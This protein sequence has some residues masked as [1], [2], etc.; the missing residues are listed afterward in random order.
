MRYTVAAQSS[1]KVRSSL[2]RRPSG[3]NAPL[4]TVRDLAVT[5]G[6]ICYPTTQTLNAVCVCCL[7]TRSGHLRNACCVA[8]SLR[9]QTCKSEGPKCSHVCIIY[10]LKNWYLAVP[11]RSSSVVEQLTADQQVIGSNPMVDFMPLYVPLL[12]HA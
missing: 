6:R 3:L 1:R 9:L 11:C 2:Q 10:A 4:L 5:R 12:M 8:S 7:Q